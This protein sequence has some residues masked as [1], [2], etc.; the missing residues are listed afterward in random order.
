MLY[1]I[2]GKVKCTPIRR[3][4][5]AG[6]YGI[7]LVWKVLK[8]FT[9]DVPACSIMQFRF[10]CDKLAEAIH[11]QVDRQTRAQDSFHSLLPTEVLRIII[12]FAGDS[13]SS[14]INLALVHTSWRDIALPL[15]WHSINVEL[16]RASDVRTTAADTSNNKRGISID[17]AIL[18]TRGLRKLTLTGAA[19]SMSVFEDPSMSELT[20]LTLHLIKLRN[21]SGLNLPFHL[22]SLSITNG[23]LPEDLLDT[24]LSSIASG[25]S[26]TL[27]RLSLDSA[28]AVRKVLPTFSSNLVELSLT[29]T[30]SH[31]L[32]LD[33]PALRKLTLPLSEL[34]VLVDAAST[35]KISDT[36]PQ[37]E[38]LTFLCQSVPVD[39][40]ALSGL[41]RLLHLPL[42]ANLQTL[43]LEGAE[44]GVEFDDAMKQS[45]MEAWRI[46]MVA[47][48]E[49]GIV[50]KVNGERQ[51]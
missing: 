23:N 19:L 8:S 9:Y 37:L 24:L 41:D 21:P 39:Y 43:A 44:E 38:G 4:A 3:L 5:L 51:W 7:E 18:A 31:Y 36:I 48:K 50:V 49:R 40:D 1:G 32:S 34:T 42:C 26:T 47:C 22:R 6:P 13:R 12:G 14:M 25:S 28:E 10:I 35:G 20:D 30:E 29:N 46:E 16:N 27:E 45:E 17:R 11:K 2:F 33:F 15:Y